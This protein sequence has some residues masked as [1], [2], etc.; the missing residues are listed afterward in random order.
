MKH[1]LT[2]KGIFAGFFVRIGVLL[3]FV[4]LLLIYYLMT[5]GTGGKSDVVISYCEKN[6]ETCAI[7]PE[8]QL[9]G[10]LKSPI[11]Y[12]D[13]HYSLAELMIHHTLNPEELT[14]NK[15]KKYN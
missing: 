12:E 3:L 14:L 11:E 5:S 8:T 13:T 6:A 9:L 1:K 10:L 2:K 7:A 15:L 4:L